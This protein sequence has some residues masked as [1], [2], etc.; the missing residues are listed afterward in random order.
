M[1]DIK[2]LIGQRS[3]KKTFHVTEERLKQFCAAIGAVYEGEAPP[4]FMTIFRES[5]FRVFSDMNIALSRVLHADQEYRYLGK[6]LPGDD[7]EFDTVLTKA[8]EKQISTG[9]SIFM[10]YETEIRALRG[11]SAVPVGVSKT[12]VII[13]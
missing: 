11:G 2:S 3:E 1:S 6:I 12:T 13:R 4:T 8:V 9:S 10:V 5:E 7:L